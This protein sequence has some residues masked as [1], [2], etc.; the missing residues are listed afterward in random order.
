MKIIVDGELAPRP[1]KK[2]DLDAPTFHEW[3][4]FLR[5]VVFIIGVVIL[6]VERNHVTTT[7]FT[8]GE[9]LAG[10]PAVLTAVYWLFLLLRLGWRVG[11]AAGDALVAT[12]PNPTA[13]HAQL[14]EELGR[15]P[16]IVEVAAVHQ[17]MTAEYN[18]GVVS[19]VATLGMAHY[20]TQRHN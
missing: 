10:V 9:W 5:L 18:R 1:A 4:M 8:I 19:A 6:V 11:S 2:Q 15:E 14:R 7:T 12:P 3:T 13:I 16:T 17:M 20:L